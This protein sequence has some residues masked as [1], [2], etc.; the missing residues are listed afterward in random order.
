MK[1]FQFCLIKFTSKDTFCRQSCICQA[2]IYIFLEFL[3]IVSHSLYICLKPFD[4]SKK[5]DVEHR[6]K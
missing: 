2:F 4:F 3:E 6:V 1:K 5:I